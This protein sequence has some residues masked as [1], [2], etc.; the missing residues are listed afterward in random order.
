MGCFVTK[1]C[2]TL[3]TG[4]PLIKKVILIFPATLIIFLLCNYVYASE[5][6][7]AWDPNNET[8][9]AGYKAHYGT[10]SGN[11]SFSVDVGKHESVSISGLEIGKLYF[12]AVT[13]YDLSG[14][15]SDYS[16]EISYRVPPSKGM[17]WILLLLLDN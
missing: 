7:L 10:V 5:L 16:A 9:L 15:E 1:I 17:P 2:F 12:F 11:Y 6:V 13:A 4:N 3:F 14:N 8:D